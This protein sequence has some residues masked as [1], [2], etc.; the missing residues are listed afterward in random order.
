MLTNSNNKYLL[1][2]SS[3]DA[4][5]IMLTTLRVAYMPQAILL[6]SASIQSDSEFWDGITTSITRT[7]HDALSVVAIVRLMMCFMRRDVYDVVQ[8]K[9]EARDGKKKKK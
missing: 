9:I 4:A 5:L 6:T 3:V 7:I 2:W 1:S 8:L